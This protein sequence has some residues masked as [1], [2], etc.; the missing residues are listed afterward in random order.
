MKFGRGD[1]GMRAI[2]LW[3]LGTLGLVLFVVA[4]KSKDDSDKAT[5]EE[6]CENMFEVCPE[7]PYTEE[8]CIDDATNRGAP[9]S[10]L[11]CVAASESCAEVIDC[12]GISQEEFDAAVS[13]WMNMGGAGS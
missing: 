6:A 5:P 10:E 4:C 11:N 2:Q 13:V 7:F 3:S 9:Q 1:E 12:L 8:R